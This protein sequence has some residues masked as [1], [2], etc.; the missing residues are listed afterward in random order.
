[1]PAKARTKYKR[2]IGVEGMS[3]PRQTEHSRKKRKLE[4]DDEF[5]RND[6]E[7]SECKFSKFYSNYC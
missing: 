3:A 1:M 7:V 2:Y 4:R 5:V 6:Q